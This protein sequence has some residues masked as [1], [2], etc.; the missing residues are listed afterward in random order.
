MKSVGRFAFWKCSGLK[1]LTI[2]S[3]VT[4]IG[5]YAFLACDDLESI[6]VDNGNTKYDSR[7]NCNAIIDKKRNTLITGCKTTIIPNSVTTIGECAFFN[8]RGLT[9][10]NIPN[11]VT[12]IRGQAFAGC[13]GLTSLTIGNSVSQIIDYAFSNCTCLTE[14]A[15]P[16][17]VYA[18]GCSVFS[19]CGL[20]KVTIGKSVQSIGN[21]AFEYC[22]YLTEIWSKIVD[23][24]GMAIGY[25]VFN[26]VPT[27]TCVL[28]V[29]VGTS[30]K[31]KN[32]YAWKAFSHI[33]EYSS[34]GDVNAD[35][36]VDGIDLNTI[37]NIVLG[38]DG[39]N[40]GGRADL[41]G[42]GE[43]NGDD[44]NQLINLLLNKQ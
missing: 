28:K 25:N 4:S 13:D 23:I 20:T 36:E 12:I 8:C 15:I 1:E 24:D 21:N 29:P 6:K 3:S 31:Y 43:V 17:S 5:D 38:K 40:Y 37:I 10:I 16:N 44:I 30:D 7:N 42:D 9:S 33:V 2:G 18:I 35:G 32:A 27:S 14:V 11:S 19:N 39:G 26:Y 41:V 34:L 22:F